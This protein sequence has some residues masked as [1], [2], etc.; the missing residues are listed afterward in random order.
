M[1]FADG[2]RRVKLE[3]M[4]KF[5][6]SLPKP[7]LAALVIGAALIFFMINDPPNTVCDIQ[8][9]NLKESLKGQ[10]FPAVDSKK[11]KLPPVIVQAQEACQQGNSAGS[12]YEYFSILRKE[13]R[14]IRNFSSQCRA[15]LLGVSEVNKSLRDGITLLTKM[16]WGSR[17]PEPGMARFGWL[18]DSELSLFCLIKDVYSQSLG[19]ETWT[20]IRQNVFKE[21]PGEPPLSKP[22]SESI[23]VE[24]PKAI[25]SMQEKDIWARSVFSV[26]CENYR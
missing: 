3:A 26:R 23:G 20:E 17:P 1:I 6:N 5:F 7:A 10:V 9:G 25:L 24:P 15:E 16:A 14:E 22:G 2:L 8:A 19:E 4:E 18:S 13:A 11:R 21:L 12:C